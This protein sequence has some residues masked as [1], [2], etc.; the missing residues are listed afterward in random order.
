MSDR[1]II[2]VC[3]MDVAKIYKFKMLIGL[4]IIKCHSAASIRMMM[5]FL[6]HNV[7]HQKIEKKLKSLENDHCT[8]S[9]FT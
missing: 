4:F 7:T 9:H 1:Y 6:T 2:I 3:V 8:V 5:D